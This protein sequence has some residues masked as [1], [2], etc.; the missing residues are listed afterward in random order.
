[1]SRENL[2]TVCVALG[3]NLGER[4]LC[5]DQAVLYLR[6]LSVDHF[7]QESPRFQ[8]DPVDC[9]PGSEPFLNSVA[10]IH[11][12]LEG[13]SPQRLLPLLQAFE[14]NL[15]R[16]VVR[17]KNAPRPIDLDIIFYGQLVI[18]EADLVVPHP[19]AHLRPFVLEPL[20]CLL[21]HSV[22]PGQTR[23]VEELLADLKG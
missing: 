11:L 15:G 12:P 19:R 13:W 17:E 2:V 6:S 7:L 16:P 9:P 4:A 8:T 18:A 21:P 23:T 22:L 10:L 14:V 5:L 3:S 20:S 1:M